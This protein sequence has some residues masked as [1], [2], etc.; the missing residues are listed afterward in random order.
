MGTVDLTL[1]KQQVGVRGDDVSL[2]QGVVYRLTKPKDMSSKDFDD[3]VVPKVEAMAA[4]FAA[5]LIDEGFYVP[6]NPTE[7]TN[8]GVYL[9]TGRTV[10]S[11][12]RTEE[13]SP[14]F[15]GT[16]AAYVVF[17]AQ[18]HEDFSR[19]LKAETELREPGLDNIEYTSVN[20][21]KIYFP[22]EP[23]TEEMVANHEADIELESVSVKETKTFTP[24]FDANDTGP[25]SI[26]MH[27][28]EVFEG[29]YLLNR[30]EETE[31]FQPPH[32]DITHGKKGAH[33]VRA[34]KQANFVRLAKDLIGLDESEHLGEDFTYEA[35]DCNNRPH[36]NGT[37]IKL[38]VPDDT[39][40]KN[41]ALA[42]AAETYCKRLNGLYH[43]SASGLSPKAVPKPSQL[44]VVTAKKVAPLL[45]R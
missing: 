31:F 7:N 12:K 40:N 39:E 43:N 1:S 18:H 38:D 36:E 16:Q 20:A 45:G 14:N 28:G 26:I 11:D 34:E 19:M 30:K 29:D 37:L 41:E 23:I 21:R 15:V 8:T 25:L 17:L 3:L 35:V 5:L 32:S 27:A 33:A 13:S 44:L 42:A 22:I 4:K 9:L 2:N 24:P 10:P 6:K